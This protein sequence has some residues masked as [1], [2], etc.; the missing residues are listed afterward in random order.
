MAGMSILF[1]VCEKTTNPETRKSVAEHMKHT[2]KTQERMYNL[3]DRTKA[4]SAAANTVLRALTGQ[5]VSSRFY[6]WVTIF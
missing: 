3:A 2:Q 4:S 1:Q 6:L 5:D